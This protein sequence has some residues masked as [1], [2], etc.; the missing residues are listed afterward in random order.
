MGQSGT[1]TTKLRVTGLTL[2]TP[3]P[4]NSA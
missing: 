1:Q 2:P 3:G 4:K